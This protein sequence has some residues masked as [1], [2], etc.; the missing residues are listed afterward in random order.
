MTDGRKDGAIEKKTWIKPALAA[1]PARG[2]EAGPRN[3]SKNDGN[4]CQS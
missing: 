1:H 2:A 3:V 4:S